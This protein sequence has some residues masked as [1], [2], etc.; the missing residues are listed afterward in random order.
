MSKVL[1]LFILFFLAHTTHAQ[2]GPAFIIDVQTEE[3]IQQLA[4]ADFNNDGLNDILTAIRKWPN[5]KMKWFL[6][7]GNNQYLSQ[8]IPA[9][10]S[11]TELK[12]F[13]TGDINR[14]GWMDFIISSESP[15]KLT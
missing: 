12:M 14:D 8:S 1:T 15:Y 13:D 9:A 4:C 7:Q 11:L 10:D 5:D 6:N 2:F 3:T